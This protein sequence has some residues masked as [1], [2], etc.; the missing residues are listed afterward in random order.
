MNPFS[1]PL[2]R[3]NAQLNMATHPIMLMLLNPDFPL[4]DQRRVENGALEVS[5]IVTHF[6]TR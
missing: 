3:K 2:D 5:S 4:A 1:I 6:I